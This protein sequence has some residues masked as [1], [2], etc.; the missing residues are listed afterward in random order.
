MEVL[1]LALAAV[2]VVAVLVGAA[3]PPRHANHAGLRVQVGEKVEPEESGGRRGIPS[4]P[5]QVLDEDHPHVDGERQA[6][7]L[8]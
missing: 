6:L 2:I 3:C 8:G 5:V 7:A 1:V 4:L